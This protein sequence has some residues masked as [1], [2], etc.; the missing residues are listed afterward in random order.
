MCCCVGILRPY[1][2]STRSPDPPMS[3]AGSKVARLSASILRSPIT[4]NDMVRATRTLTVRGSQPLSIGQAQSTRLAPLSDANRAASRDGLP[5]APKGRKVTGAAARAAAS[6]AFAA[7]RCT[8]TIIPASPTPR[9]V[10]RTV[11]PKASPIATE[12]PS[13]LGPHCRRGL[14]ID[15]EPS[16]QWSSDQV[17]KRDLDSRRL[18]DRTRPPDGNPG[19]APRTTEGSARDSR[20]PARVGR[21]GCLAGSLPRCVE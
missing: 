9:A 12:P 11:T 17:P 4:G 7:A 13:A 1:S 2:R 14:E 21:G 20:G 6:A 5:T 15:R 19:P 10:S 18:S 3:A 8:A 16:E